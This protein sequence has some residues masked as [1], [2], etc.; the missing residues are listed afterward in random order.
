MNLFDENDKVMVIDNKMTVMIERGHPK[1]YIRQGEPD[2][3]AMSTGN[4]SG[5][6]I[7]M[8]GLSFG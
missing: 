8:C 1:V 6:Y 3:A 5:L 4:V 2:N 7:L